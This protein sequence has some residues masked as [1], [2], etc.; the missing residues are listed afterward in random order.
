MLNYDTLT[1]KIETKVSISELSGRDKVNLFRDLMEV[2]GI[3]D[4]IIRGDDTTDNI[5]DKQLKIHWNK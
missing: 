2:L 3:T 1:R 4:A 5:I